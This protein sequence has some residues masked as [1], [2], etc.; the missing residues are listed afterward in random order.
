MNKHVQAVLLGLALA[1]AAGAAV[2]QALTVPALQRLLQS[3]AKSSVA[4]EEVRESPWLPAPIT[5]RGTLRST[6]AALEKRV[7]SPRQET[8]RLL[9][10]R[11]EWTSAGGERKQVTFAQAPALA[12]LS[13]VMRGVVAGDLAALEREFRI[14]IN[15]DERVWRALLQPRNNE[16]GRRLESVELQGTGGR[17]QVIIVVER[18]GERTTTRLQP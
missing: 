4:F 17:L 13:A 5:S 16:V 12:A 6:P 3:S 14:E 15:G 9:A 8:W 11:I 1:C 10:D 2:A 18:Q 7:E